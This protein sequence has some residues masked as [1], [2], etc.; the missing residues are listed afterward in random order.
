MAENKRILSLK[1]IIEIVADGYR[2]ETLRFPHNELFKE[3]D[4]I[5]LYGMHIDEGIKKE[6]L[7]NKDL[8]IKE[9]RDTILHE[10]YH[11]FYSRE[12][13]HQSEK[14]INSIVRMHYKKLYEK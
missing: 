5:I 4:D 10:F 2:I 8:C 14:M 12:G 3:K 9:R 11:A 7:I 6:I 13:W 1:D